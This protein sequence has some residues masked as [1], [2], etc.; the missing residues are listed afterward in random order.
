MEQEWDL[1][2]SLLESMWRFR[3]LVI[4]TVVIAA[5]AG[6]GL[7]QLQPTMYEGKTSLILSD[8]RNAGVFRDETRLVI[9][10]S[11]YVRNQAELITLTEVLTRAVQLEGGRVSVEDLKRTVTADASTNLDLITI[12][13]LDP[14]PEGAASL[15]DSVG[16]AYEQIVT[17][18]VKANADAAL[19]E[20]DRSRADTQSQIDALE[21]KLAT[22]PNDSA[23]KA[24]RDAAVAQLV[25]LKNR[26]EQISVDAA[27]YGT[28]VQLFEASEIPKSPASPRPKRNAAVAG[29]LGLLAASAYAW[30]RAEHTQ[31]AEYRQDAAPVLGA[32][33]LGE[34]PDFAT[35]GVTGPA[36]ALS[37][38]TSPAGDAYQFI[39]SSLEFA[40]AEAGGT[41]VL[42][43]SAGPTDGKT[44]TTLN[45]GVAAARDGRK[46]LLVDADER[47]RG[48]SRFLGAGPEPGITD[49]ASRDIKFADAVR[50]MRISDTV[51]LPVVPAGSPVDD[52]AGFFRTPGF[53]K[54]MGL[55]RTHA[56]LIL[57][58]SPPL[59]AVADTSAIASQ[60]DGIVLVV[61][62]GTPIRVLEDAR[63]R[64]AFIGTPLLGYVFNRSDLKGGRYGY[65]KYRYGRYGSYGYGYGYGHPNG[66]DEEDEKSKHRRGKRRA[67]A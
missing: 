7:S 5:L 16:H 20:L 33:L 49:L 6:F 59:L 35:V 28:G 43:T 31:A 32:P 18:E 53:R 2:P 54:A 45:L 3:R 10:P 64:M 42:V 17:E 67:K 52:T 23:T 21:A 58:D 14:T 63:E 61:D 47:I 57:V 12:R 19:A 50:S 55:I 60:T 15:S 24:E 40:L 36:P 62:K 30:W 41:M 22:D 46:V 39:V 29:I 11:R 34:V 38:P 1:G 13:A 66:Q 37:A 56:D 27:L 65:K 51:H 9:D 25:T 8:P 26:A 44:V 4:L 48:L